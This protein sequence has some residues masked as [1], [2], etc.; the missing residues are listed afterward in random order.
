MLTLFPPG[1]D[2][3]SVTVH[4]LVN[5]CQ[6]RIPEIASVPSHYADIT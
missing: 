5:N 2:G 3:L 1:L 4:S 6:Q